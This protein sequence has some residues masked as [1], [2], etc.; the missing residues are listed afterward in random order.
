[1]PKQTAYNQTVKE[2]QSKTKQAM[3]DILK[4]MPIIQFAVKKAGISRD[5][6]YRWKRED[7]NFFRQSEDAFAQGI[8]FVNDMSESQIIQSIK[9]KKIPAIVLWL[10]H[11]HLRYGAKTQGYTPASFAVELSAK[12][13]KIVAK[14]LRLA[15]GKL[16]QHKK[17]ER[18]NRR[19]IAK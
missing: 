2:R 4:E 16:T 19:I 9:E 3:I 8:E 18:E 15:S 6:Y 13:R 11:H 17:Y 12:E 10:R 5:T 7:K 1:M 14:A